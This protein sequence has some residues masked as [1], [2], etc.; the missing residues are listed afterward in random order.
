MADHR[1]SSGHT[2]PIRIPTFQND[3]IETG[4]KGSAI[5]YADKLG[6]R[7]VDERFTT[8][9]IRNFY[10]E[11]KRIQL[12]GISGSISSF[13]LLHPKIAYAAKRAEK[14]GSRGA[15]TFKEEILKAHRAVR[16]DEDGSEKRFQNFCD[17][18]EAILAFH[19]ASG[20]RD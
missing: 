15:N 20:G 17:L 19:K 5:E 16:I 4:I 13:H 12:N 7:L 9:Q 8:S 10:G 14:M 18:C 2:E 1:Q 3:W 6:Q 11:L